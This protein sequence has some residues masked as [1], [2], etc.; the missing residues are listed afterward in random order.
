LFDGVVERKRKKCESP[1]EEVLGPASKS[2][3]QSFG[4]TVVPGIILQHISI[5]P[6]DD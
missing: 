5:Y 4:N 1:R 2:R 3:P 6:A